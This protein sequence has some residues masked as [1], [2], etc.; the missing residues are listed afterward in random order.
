MGRGLL[1]GRGLLA[2][3]A[4]TMIALPDLAQ[5]GQCDDMRLTIDKFWSLGRDETTGKI[6]LMPLALQTRNAVT[7]M[8]QLAILCRKDSNGGNVSI[9]GDGMDYNGTLKS[10]ECKLVFLGGVKEI[11]VT[12]S[13]D[14][15]G[16]E[17][18]GSFDIIR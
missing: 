4:F 15:T 16:D 12:A 6:P 5:A 11:T 2:A 14:M 1:T 9:R 10:N 13:D 7:T 8:P 17:A 18:C 3:I